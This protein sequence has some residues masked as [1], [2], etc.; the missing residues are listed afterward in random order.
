MWYTI[1]FPVV[2]CIQLSIMFVLFR[3]VHPQNGQ[4]YFS[5]ETFSRL[6]GT[7]TH[8]SRLNKRLKYLGIALDEVATDAE[9]IEDLELPLVG[10][11]ERVFKRRT[12]RDQ[13]VEVAIEL[14]GNSANTVQVAFV[15][16]KDDIVLNESGVTANQFSNTE[17]YDN[18]SGS[19]NLPT[20]QINDET[21]KDDENSAQQPK[22]FYKHLSEAV[23]NQETFHEHV[24]QPTNEESN[25]DSR[26]IEAFA[27]E[28]NTISAAQQ[29]ITHSSSEKAPGT[30]GNSE[31]TQEDK[32]EFVKLDP[33]FYNEKDRYDKFTFI[34]TNIVKKYSK[35][36]KDSSII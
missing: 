3:N 16:P 12:Q 21:H 23:K 25:K 17:C 20:R 2:S 9:P 13:L 10:K 5:E 11:Q 26:F 35:T 27:V 19:S 29:A 22:S 7:E 30:S 33:A 8:E 14:P 18:D 31:G 34:S 6:L 4:A 15:K 32:R 24:K 28:Q 36:K 1:P